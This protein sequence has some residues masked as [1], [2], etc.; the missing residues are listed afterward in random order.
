VA[1]LIAEAKATKITR[2]I[3]LASRRRTT[4]KLELYFWERLGEIARLQGKSL[5]QLAGDIDADRSGSLASAIRLYVAEFYR[6][7]AARQ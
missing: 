7:S 4:V 5:G 2:A 6:S 1:T 3:V